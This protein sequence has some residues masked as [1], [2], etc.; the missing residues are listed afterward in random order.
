ME[1]PKCGYEQPEGLKECQR[2]GIIFQKWLDRQNRPSA[3]APIPPTIYVHSKTEESSGGS[4]KIV[5]ILIAVTIIGG[6][7]WSWNKDETTWRELKPEGK[8]FSVLLQGTPKESENFYQEGLVSVAML[9][10]TSEPHFGFTGVV[11][12]ALV[13]DISYPNFMTFDED[14]GYEGGLQALMKK[15]PNSKLAS[16][17][18][19][20][21]AGYHGRE[22]VISCSKG[23]VTSRMLKK[24]DRIYLL[25]MLHPENK[26]YSSQKDKFFGSFNLL[27]N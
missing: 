14:K 6:I 12:A 20:K 11:Y 10:Y 13:G 9:I 24:G 27:K 3:T 26:N 2:C 16:Q 4:L 18:R 5:K 7:W 23:L 1:C 22:F 17:A 15:L 8:G 21:V 19:I 25:M